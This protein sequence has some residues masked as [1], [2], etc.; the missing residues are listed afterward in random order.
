MMFTHR[1]WAVECGLSESFSGSLL[2]SESPDSG[3]IQPDVCLLLLHQPAP[4][5]RSIDVTLAMQHPF[6]CIVILL[7]SGP[8]VGVALRVATEE[9][10]GSPAP[11]QTLAAGI[12]S[13]FIVSFHGL[14]FLFYSSSLISSFSKLYKTFLAK[15]F[16]FP[17]F[18]KILNDVT[19]AMVS[20]QTIGPIRAC[21]A[22]LVMAQ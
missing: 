15:V 5:V 7:P 21:Y 3:P 10:L 4:F 19:D 12:F 8:A 16:F 20:N 9:G 17:F 14:L 1:L 6:S 11:T 18:Y 22:W 2:D 13:L